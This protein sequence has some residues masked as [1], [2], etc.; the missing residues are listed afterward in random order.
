M[1]RRSF[2]YVAISVCFVHVNCLS[3]QFTH[4]LHML[5]WFS[6]HSAQQCEQGNYM[7][8]TGG[9]S[10][11][12]VRSVSRLILLLDPQ[13]TEQ[14]HIEAPIYHQCVHRFDTVV[15]GSGNVSSIL[16]IHINSCL[17]FVARPLFSLFS[18]IMPSKY[19]RFEGL[20]VKT[21]WLCLSR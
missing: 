13:E 6:P 16:I 11:A 19:Y 2:T 14:S 20:S 7:W 8:G 1:I 12:R 18:P 4:V 10:G 15:L 5:G 17:F 21:K 3:T 9:V